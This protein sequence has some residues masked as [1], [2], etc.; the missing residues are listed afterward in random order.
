M[1]DRRHPYYFIMRSSVKVLFVITFFTLFMYFLQNI[2]NIMA[3]FEEVES[4]HQMVGIISVSNTNGTMKLQLEHFKRDK[5]EHIKDPSHR[6]HP[7]MMKGVLILHNVCIQ[8][9][10]KRRK[11]EVQKR[12][13]LGT[14]LNMSR[15]VLVAYNAKRTTTQVHKVGA[16]SNVRVRDWEIMYKT[17]S[18]PKGVT[19]IDSHDAYFMT[20]SCDGNLWLFFEDSLRGLYSVVKRTNRLESKEKNTVYYREPL[21]EYNTLL[22]KYVQCWDPSR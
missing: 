9:D 7:F 12:L 15:N 19:V 3:Y 17:G 4:S 2:D 20:T 16:H 11:V 6:F 5:D 18:P 8:P 14:H 21:W 22:E 1:G 10:P 13:K